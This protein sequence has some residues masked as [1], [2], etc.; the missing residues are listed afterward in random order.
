MNYEIRI[1]E[2]I[3]KDWS[4]WFDGFQIERDSRGET[5]L[6]GSVVDSAALLVE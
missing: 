6:I 5:V 1:K 3:D 4:D 2:G